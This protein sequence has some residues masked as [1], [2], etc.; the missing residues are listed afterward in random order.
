MTWAKRGHVGLIDGFN[1]CHHWRFVESR[2]YLQN[3]AS[4]VLYMDVASQSHPG[5]LNLAASLNSM[6]FNI[7]IA[8]GSA[9]GGLVNAHLGLMWLGPVGA[10]FL[11]CAVG[12]TTL[13]RPF[14]ARERD[15]YTKQQA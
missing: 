12:T 3:S 11:L 1:R 5:S 13:L 10:I 15:F 7:G 9:V 6:S 14:V 2:M 8:V 4:Q